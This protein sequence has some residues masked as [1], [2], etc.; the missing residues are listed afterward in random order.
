[1]KVHIGDN[2]IARPAL[3]DKVNLRHF[4]PRAAGNARFSPRYK[5]GD[6]IFVYFS[7][8]PWYT[9][10]VYRYLTAQRGLIDDK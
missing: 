7:H 2:I 3:Q 8:F 4:S 10:G 1:M 9:I 6:K 5:A